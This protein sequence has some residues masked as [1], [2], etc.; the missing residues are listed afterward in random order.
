MNVFLTGGGTGGHIF[1]AIAIAQAIEAKEPTAN[2]H[3]VGTQYGME[4]TLVPDA[5]YPL[6][7]LP[8]RGFL[9]KNL[10]DKLHLLWRLPA[11][12]ILAFFLILRFRPKVVIGV[13]GY[14]SGPML[15]VASFL[16]IP[17]MIQEQ[18]A[19]PGLTNKLG[20]KFSQL[21]CLGFK[22]ADKFLSCRS[23]VTGNPVRGMFS[24]IKPWKSDR[25]NLLILGGSQGAR[26]LNQVLPQ[27][28]KEVLKKDSEIQVIH[29]CGKRFIDQVKDAYGEVN[30]SLEITPFIQDM[31]AA[32]NEARLIMCRSGAST[33]AELKLAGVPAL[34]VPFPQATGDH[35]TFNAKSLE[36]SGAGILIPE[37]QL[38]NAA[39]QLRE[40]LEDPEKLSRMAQAY[41]P[42]ERNAAEVCA[43][44]ALALKNR[45]EVGDLVSKYSHHVP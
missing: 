38:P 18:N 28:L 8:I 16:R 31:P 3:F 37:D 7:T 29:Q 24:G 10:M 36:E 42:C 4:T 11:S 32:M 25:P 6:H 20:A 15:L 2:I 35:Q 26:S 34:L 40:L 44:I 30:F 22:E 41:P 9:G 45:Q 12:L 33:I 13:G 27:V 43:E 5:G 1:P 19:Y 14:A 39:S 23:I 17:T 21:A